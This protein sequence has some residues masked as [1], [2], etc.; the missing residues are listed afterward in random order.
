MGLALISLTGNASTLT[1]S[2]TGSA[3]R[4]WESWALGLKAFGTY[5][6]SR[7]PEST[8]SQVTALAAG[9]QVR[10][11]RSLT[12]TVSAYLSTGGEA[13]HVKSIEFLGFGEGGAGIVWVERA[14][15]DLQKLLLRTDLGLR[16]AREYQFQYYP[17]PLDLPDR[18]L[19]GPKVG[20]VLKYALSKDIAIAEE[21]ELLASL[22]GPSRLLFSST[23]K[24][25]SRLTESVTLGVAF[26]LNS[27]S[28]PAPGKVSTDTA[29]IVGLEV[30]L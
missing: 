19:L 30:A 5:G 29:L 16:Y 10:G 27:D 4:K 21:A 25:S 14:E 9:A 15:G 26:T 12:K 28:L 11:D 7:P 2:G 20:A 17:E 24:L 22:L 1:F 23:T 8:E 13:N 3:T 18:D 6:Q